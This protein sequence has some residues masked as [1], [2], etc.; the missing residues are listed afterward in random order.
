LGA[1][2]LGGDLLIAIDNCEAPLGGEF[3]CAMLTQRLVRPRVLGRSLVPELPASAFV[4]ATGNN[5]VLLGDA[6]RRSV[7]CRLDPKCERPELRV[8]ESNPIEMVKT[9]RPRYVAA[10]LTILRAYHVAGRP[11]PPEP[12]GSFEEWSGW[13]RGALIWL[14]KADPVAT[15]E[16]VRDMDPRL[17][18][19][20][21]V[22]VQWQSVIGDAAVSAHDVIERAT[23]LTAV[24]SDDPNAPPVTY[25]TQPDFRNVL[26]GI[27]GTGDEINSKR[28]G[29]WLGLHQDRIAKGLRVVRSGLSGGILRWKVEAAGAGL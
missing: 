4:T 27:A 19:L 22:L 17:A 3:L 20:T 14:G 18:A 24:Q 1:L 11:E 13:V 10:A 25:Y 8:F 12:L 7:M 2:L 16:N 29:K 15:I 23:A 21:G 5:I 6:T 9:R 26:L 28:L